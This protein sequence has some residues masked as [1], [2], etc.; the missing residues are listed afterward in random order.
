MKRDM[1]AHRL[2]SPLRKVIQKLRTNPGENMFCKVNHC[3]Y[4]ENAYANMFCKYGE[5]AGE[6]MFCK[7]NH[8]KYGES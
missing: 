2:G 3:K 1:H 7:V 6:N 8:C 4:R 5:N